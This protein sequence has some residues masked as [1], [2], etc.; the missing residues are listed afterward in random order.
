MHDWHRIHS[1]SNASGQ[2]LSSE[3]D[4]HHGLSHRLAL[5]GAR[6]A[7]CSDVFC[8]IEMELCRGSGILGDRIVLH[9]LE[10]LF[11]HLC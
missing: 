11:C 7:P 2:E 8:Y 6:A 4:R 3:K 10:H 5:A 9:L 1:F